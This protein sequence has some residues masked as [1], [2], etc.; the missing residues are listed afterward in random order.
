MKTDQ[1]N[2]GIARKNPGEGFCKLCKQNGN[3]NVS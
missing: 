3:L 1:W 2:F